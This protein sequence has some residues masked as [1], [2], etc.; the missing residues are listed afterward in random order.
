MK[1][2]VITGMSI[3]ILAMIGC[4]TSS[5]P[6]LPEGI[7]AIMIDISYVT[8]GDG[9]PFSGGQCFDASVI[10]LSAYYNKITPTSDMV[11][12]EKTYQDE[13]NQNVFRRFLRHGLTVRYHRW[14]LIEIHAW[15]QKGNPMIAIIDGSRPYLHAIIIIGMDSDFVYFHDPVL[16]SGR[17]MSHEDF[18]RMHIF[19]QNG[20]WIIKDNQKGIKTV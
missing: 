9:K 6:T 13:H 18:Q 10:M 16:G 14:S 20:I 3:L 1:S 4:G 7:E 19:G 5:W 17:Y 11:H 8:D 15:L 12:E 2:I